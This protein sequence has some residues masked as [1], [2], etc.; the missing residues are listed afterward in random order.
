[1]ERMFESKVAII[2]GGAR[3]MG[4][5]TALSFAKKRA[6]VEDVR[7]PCVRPNIVQWTCMRDWFGLE[8]L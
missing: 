8:E 1:M 2:T 5:A 7:R 6:S 4:R 3:G